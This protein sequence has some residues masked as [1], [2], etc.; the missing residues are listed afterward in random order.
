MVGRTFLMK[1]SAMPENTWMAYLNQEIIRRMVNTT[2]MLEEN[3]RCV[4]VD[5]YGHKIQ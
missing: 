2:K 4:A 1:R 3:T 5:N